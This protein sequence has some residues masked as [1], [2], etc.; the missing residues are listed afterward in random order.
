MKPICLGKSL[1]CTKQ[2][3]FYL[4]FLHQAKCQSKTPLFNLQ[5]HKMSNTFQ[6]RMQNVKRVVCIWQWAVAFKLIC[7]WITNIQH[8]HK[9]QYL[10]GLLCSLVSFIKFGQVFLEEKLF[11]EIVDARTDA[12]TMDH[13]QWAIT[14]AHLEHIVLR[15]PKNN[16]TVIN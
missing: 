2:S 1:R 6:Y 14:K 12:Q 8:T 11:K 3:T 7:F 10:K 4:N 5:S 15:W 16:N 9:L 13:R